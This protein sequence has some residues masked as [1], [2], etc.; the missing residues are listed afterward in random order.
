MS[1]L[2]VTFHRR[3]A[4]DAENFFL[5]QTGHSWQVVVLFGELF[6]SSKPIDGKRT[7][8]DFRFTVQ[9]KFTNSF[10]GTRA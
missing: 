7:N 2:F 8:P 1:G 5:D 10:A 3:D 9:Y 4:K 6:H